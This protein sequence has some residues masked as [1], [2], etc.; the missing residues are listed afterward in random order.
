MSV[1]ASLQTQ[2][3]E[4]EAVFDSYD[5]SIRTGLLELRELIL[6]TAADTDGVGPLA[7][8]LR[9]G[10][11]AYIT[12]ATRSGS[13]IRL[14]PASPESGADYAMFFICTTNLVDTFRS[15][16]GDTFSYDGK[17]AL[18]FDVGDDR[19]EAELRE[20]IALALTYHLTGS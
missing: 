16:F 6:A 18:L 13:T 10:E 2:P 15:L 1:P 4:V 9:W 12:N 20:C 7:E 11:P 3:V 5:E 17:R 14:A 19:P 8:V